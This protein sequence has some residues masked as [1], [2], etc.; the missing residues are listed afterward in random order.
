MLHPEAAAAVI[1]SEVLPLDDFKFFV[2][3]EFNLKKEVQSV[4]MSVLQ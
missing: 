4:E 3:T 1:S 2:Y